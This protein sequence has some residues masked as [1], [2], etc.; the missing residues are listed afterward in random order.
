MLRTTIMENDIIK[1]CTK[2]ESILQFLNIHFILQMLTNVLLMK[3][4]I[5]MPMQHVQI[6]MV[7]LHVLVMKGTLEMARTVKVS[8]NLSYY[9][10]IIFQKKKNDFLENIVF[11]T[12]VLIEK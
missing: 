5:V 1:K 3:R 7:R 6:Q 10:T 4:T 11:E 8:L 12:L 2:N 9:S